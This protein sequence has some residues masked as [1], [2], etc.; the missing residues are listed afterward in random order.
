MG[1]VK[2][3]RQIGM[4][5]KGRSALM[6]EQR[7][8]TAEEC[9]ARGVGFGS[10]HP[11]RRSSIV[12][13]VVTEL[14]LRSTAQL[15][16]APRVGVK[17]LAEQD[18]A[19]SGDTID[20]GGPTR[21]FFSSLGVALGDRSQL[22]LFE[23]TKSQ[24]LLQP[25]PLIHNEP[26]LADAVEREQ[27]YRAIGR[28]AG[29][30][31]AT[32]NRLGMRFARFFLRRVL[33]LAKVNRLKAYRPTTNE[34]ALWLSDGHRASLARGDQGC[35]PASLPHALARP[36]LLSRPVDA[37]VFV[38]AQ[39]ANLRRFIIKHDRKRVEV[40]LAAASKFGD[41]KN[42]VEATI[43]V[44]A[45][46]QKYLMN[47]ELREL[48]DDD[49]MP[50]V[51]EVSL[52]GEVEPGLLKPDPLQGRPVPLPLHAG[53]L[54]SSEVTEGCCVLPCWMLG[55][56][57]IA[58]GADIQAERLDDLAAATSA[59]FLFS[60]ADRK[61]L[62]ASAE[63]AEAARKEAQQQLVAS[64]NCLTAGSSIPLMLCGKER[65]VHVVAL[66]GGEVQAANLKR[67]GDR[68]K[69]HMHTHAYARAL[70][71]CI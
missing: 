15:R 38:S 40:S 27:H 16:A 56:L 53:V 14:R 33:E 47:K 9:D 2:I 68:V 43:G 37:P 46:S 1:C 32:D 18:G 10:D 45:T 30:A 39:Q 28:A 19:N 71:L 50:E 54:S 31:F 61:E 4:P 13:D 41:F 22:R 66:N 23:L 36:L 55:A 8:Y 69:L 62:A 35:F 12:L 58:N 59:T 48:R 21:Q 3:A 67:D 70:Q 26:G 49:V 29:L 51:S 34:A 44:R 60:D 5:L 25:N 6:R 17:F 20:I 42:L 63:L 24:R 57:S 65:F 11:L 7:V 52:L 64:F